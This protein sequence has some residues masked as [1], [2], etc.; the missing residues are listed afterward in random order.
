MACRQIP[1]YP[2]YSPRVSCSSFAIRQGLRTAY[3][4]RK[5]QGGKFVGIL[6]IGI[7]VASL[8]VAY[9]VGSKLNSWPKGILAFFIAAAV[10]YIVPTLIIEVINALF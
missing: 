6:V 1:V 9:T 2:D 10:F 8:F 7:F 3:N 4:V 5:H